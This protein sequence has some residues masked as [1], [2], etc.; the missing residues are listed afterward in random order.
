MK[1]TIML[2][3]ID[4]ITDLIYLFSEWCMI[5]PI[6]LVLSDWASF[7][8][9]HD[10][11][12]MKEKL[13]SGAQIWNLTRVTW[14]KPNALLAIRHLSQALVPNRPIRVISVRRRRKISG[15]ITRT[16]RCS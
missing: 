11:I 15:V 7:I 2:L 12:M 16:D 13:Q 6:E 14:R 3:C 9:R 8:W 5:S 10:P 1:D 4:V